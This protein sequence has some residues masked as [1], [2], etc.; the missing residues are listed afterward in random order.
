MKHARPVGMGLRED[1]HPASTYRTSPVCGEKRSE[2]RELQ[3]EGPANARH[4]PK[5]GRFENEGGVGAGP[6]EGEQGRQ[7]GVRP[8]KVRVLPSGQQEEAP[9]RCP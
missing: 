6:S 3:V 8:S 5:P 4:L 1:S 7:A 9:G 2:E